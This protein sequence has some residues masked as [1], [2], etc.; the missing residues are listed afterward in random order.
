MNRLIMFDI[1]GTLLKVDAEDS[2]YESAIIEL[3]DNEEK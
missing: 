2:L 1:D 3:I